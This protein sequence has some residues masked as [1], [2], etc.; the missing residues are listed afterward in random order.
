[1]YPSLTVGC[2]GCRLHRARIGHAQAAWQLALPC[3]LGPVPE[4]HFDQQTVGGV[5]ASVVASAAGMAAGL[6]LAGPPGAAAGAVT[7]P[8]LQ[9]LINYLGLRFERARHKAARVLTD[10]ADQNHVSEDELIDQAERSPQKTE[11]VAEVV[12]AAA[13]AT[14]EQ[15]LSAL[16][17]SLARG[18]AG[19]DYAAARERL[20]VAALADLEPIH[21]AVMSCLRS[22]PPMYGSDEDWRK[23]M[24]ERPAGAYGWL[25]AE[26]MGRLPEAAPVIDAVFAALQRHGLVIDTA[27][28]TVSYQ[29]RYVV[30]D[31]GLR[32]L[33]WLEDH[34]SDDSPSPRL[35]T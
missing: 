4:E 7:A 28:G 31:F 35:E 27:I 26:V 34:D 19:D 30:T 32:C 10:A 9:A 13:R 25:P 23:A 12:N 3:I 15:K 2:P 8:A 14:T 6:A 29:E 16:A 21:L 22:R 1:M 5:A 20:I 11:L 17:S 24:S 18:V 33:H